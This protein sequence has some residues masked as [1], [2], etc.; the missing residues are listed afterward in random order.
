MDKIK[1]KAPIR[2]FDVFAEWNRLKGIKE[3]GLSPEEAK[4]YGLAV[5]EVV[6]ARK[7]Y[8]HKTKYRGATKEYIEKKE[9]T[10]WWRKMATPSEFD[11]KI[12]KRMGEE[13]YEK[14]FSRAI[15]RAFNEGKD[16]MEIRDS[17]RENWNKALKER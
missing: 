12:V 10:P 13:F 7:F 16:Y 15:E 2:R 14:V 1:P 17:I 8:G 11:E 9:G 5:A 4:S 6:A 3:L